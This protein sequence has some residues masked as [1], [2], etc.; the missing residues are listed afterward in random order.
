MPV[1]RP[2]P[3]G[4]WEAYPATDENSLQGPI[5][6]SLLQKL[7]ERGLLDQFSRLLELGTLPNLLVMVLPV[8]LAC[9][10]SGIDLIMA[11]IQSKPI[12][13]AFKEALNPCPLEEN[14]NTSWE[15]T[16]QVLK[17][18]RVLAQYGPKVLQSLKTQGKALRPDRIHT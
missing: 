11:V 1:V 2:G 3:G 10:R 5:K 16:Y 7:V 13:T 18:V 17:V 15:T 14:L 9:G 4:V 12:L 6:G 8:L